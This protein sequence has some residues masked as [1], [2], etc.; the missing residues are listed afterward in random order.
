VVDACV[1]GL[2]HAA[3]WTLRE[4]DG[5][6]VCGLWTLDCEGSG[7]QDLRLGSERKF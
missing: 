1:L 6:Y 2:S 3:D 5:E 7:S 4:L